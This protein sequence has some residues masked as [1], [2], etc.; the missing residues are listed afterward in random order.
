MRLISFLFILFFSFH[1]SF[2]TAQKIEIL[3]LDKEKNPLV[4]ALV[5]IKNIA[6]SEEENHFTES[7]GKVIL[8]QIAYGKYPIEISYLGFETITDT[9]TIDK[10]SQNF[11]FVLEASGQVIEEIKIVGKRPLL[12]QEGDK[13]IIDPEPLLGFSTNTL[14]VLEATPGLLV[15]PEGG[16]FLNNANPASIQINGREQRM[17]TQDIMNM[18]RSLPPG[19]ILK[20]EVLRN[21]SAKYDAASSGGIINIVLKKGVK[22]GQYG[23]VNAGTNQGDE[24][25]YFGGFSF[26]NT[27]QKSG[28]SFQL[29]YNHNAVAEDFSSQRNTL[30]TPTLRQVNDNTRINDNFF[31]SL[32]Y[33]YTLKNDHQLSYFGTFQGNLNTLSSA[34]TNTYEQGLETIFSSN[35][36]INNRNPFYSHRHDL[37][38][39][40]KLDT[41]GSE[42]DGKLSLGQS[43][44]DGKQEYVFDQ[45]IP[46]PETFTGN[47]D[48]VNNRNF[49]TAQ[50]DFTKK[51][52]KIIL[53]EA[54]L[55]GDIQQFENR[56][57][58]YLPGSSGNVQDTTRSNRFNYSDN[59][60][61]AY[62][63]LSR[64]II[65]KIT[66]KAG[67]RAENT[68]MLGEQKFP[69]DTSFTVNRTDFFPY[70]FL[71]R[72]LF[73][74][75]GYPLKAFAIYRKTLNRPSY[76]NLNP[77]I[78]ILDPFNYS[79]GNP[80][81]APQFT[82]N[83]EFNIS[84]DDN[85]IFAIGR[86]YTTG[87]IS[88]VLYEDPNQPDITYNTFDNIGQS[89]E[90]YFRLVGAVP[91]GGKYFFVVGTQYNHSE[92]EGLYNGQPISFSRGS[93]RFFTFHNWKITKTWRLSMF[94]FLLAKGQQNFLELEN[95]G[96]LN[97]TL[98]KS[99]LNDRLQISVFGRDIFRT[100]ENRFVLDQGGILFEGA[101]YSDNQRWG[102]TMRYSFGMNQK[103]EQGN[104]FN[105]PGGE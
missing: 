43:F 104:I 88:N 36:Q 25:S 1:F 94:G 91:P 51:W 26:N 30:N 31:A 28:F 39:L 95:F 59:I 8:N 75:A 78:E 35:N 20:I 37:G 44:F 62:T 82:H 53:L 87:I 19:N 27:G 85:P 42:I 50:I 17:A 102:M 13:V 100:M 23:S 32:G 15:D 61:A 41:I 71:S 92:Y 70:L 4:A 98:N 96:Q 5:T 52:D 38:W 86:N 40:K 103:K 16:I 63:Q 12:R 21:P 66:V 67:V 80:A 54:G 2:S 18:L 101:R 3:V 49:L 83:Y 6:D 33:D 22:L 73:K 56:T 105:M 97:L 76:Q 45:I 64:D 34:Q 7:N 48:I 84:F 74:I 24:G 69:S 72:D 81:L 79:S 68:N 11:R 46:F 58:F 65:W 10:S 60:F 9:L 93:W 55:K 29:N 99:F 47:G 57:D 14:E 90:T 77:A 89:K